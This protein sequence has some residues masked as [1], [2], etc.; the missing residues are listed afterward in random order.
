LTAVGNSVRIRRVTEKQKITIYSAEVSNRFLFSHLRD[1][2]HDLPQAHELGLRLFKRNL[3]ALY[4]QSL[5]GFGWA[6]LPPLATAALWILLRGGDVVRMAETGVSYPVFVLTGTLL[7]QVFSEAISAPLTQVME[8]RA[9]LSKINIPREGLLLSGA[10]QLLFNIG[11]KVLLLVV[12]YLILRQTTASFSGLLFVP[13]GIFA[14]SLAGFSIGLALTPLGMLYQDINRGVAVLLPFFMYLTPVV[15]PPPQAGIL[16]LLMQWNPLAVL[17]TQTRNGFTAQPLSD[18]A[19]FWAFT[20]AFALLF[21]IS[22]VVYRLAMP[23]I[24]E[25]MGS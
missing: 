9:M 16:R 7:W 4:R 23:M 3:K 21:T 14:I 12:I 18:L 25:R 2:V 1:I 22:L 19:S 15:Y 17:I 6:L 8:N 20:L 13:V 24:I 5:L 10:Y 11:I